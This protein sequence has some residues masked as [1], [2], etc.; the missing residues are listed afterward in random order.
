MSQEERF[1]TR[2]QSYSAWHR[3]KS[4]SRFIGL[5]KAQLLAM[6][7]LDACP[8]VEY[9]DES[10]D[11]LA[12]IEVA[13]DVGQNSK[14]STVTRKLAELCN[15]PALVVLYKLD[16]DF[17][18]PA[19]ER[20][21]DICSFRVKRIHP[22]EQKEWETLTPSEYA[23]RLLRVRQWSADKKSVENFPSA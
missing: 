6:I 7:D 18:N 14:P 10:K 23:E 9:D 11:P 15:I 4:T 19:N 3:K 17:P 22:K 5:E 8:Y 12:L 13:I 21:Q 2:D 16:E 20:F 1:G